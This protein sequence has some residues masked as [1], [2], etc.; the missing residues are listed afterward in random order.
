[1]YSKVESRGGSVRSGP[2][3]RHIG[4]RLMVGVSVEND[5]GIGVE[6]VVPANL[7]HLGTIQV[8]LSEA[9]DDQGRNNASE[10]QREKPP[11]SLAR[12]LWPFS[13]DGAVRPRRSKSL[14]QRLHFEIFFFGGRKKKVGGWYRFK[15]S[16]SIQCAR[17]STFARSNEHQRGKGGWKSNK[18]E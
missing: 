9:E 3:Q 7:P 1:M 17:R 14:F 5:I 2:D 6:P 18:M 16:H 10:F 11:D 12:L 4:K 15:R 13:E 8:W